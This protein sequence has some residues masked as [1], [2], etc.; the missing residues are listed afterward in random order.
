MLKRLPKKFGLL[1]LISLIPTLALWIPFYFRIPNVM[2]IPVPENGMA[3]I[4][5]NYDGPLYIVIAKTFYNVSLIKESFSF[6]LPVQ[7]YAAHFPFYPALIFLIGSGLKAVFGNALGFTWGMLITTLISSV[8][9][10]WMFKRYIALHVDK[11]D[12]LWLTFLFAVFPARWLIVRSVGSPEPLFV[13][14]ILASIFY[15]E[16]KNYLIA[17]I[18]GALAQL[19]KS[20]GILLFVAYGL[21]LF[22]PHVKKIGN[23]RTFAWI[24]SFEWKAYPLLL[25]PISLIGLF[26]VYQYTFSDFLAYFHSGD[27]IH[28][29]FP[30]FQ[31]FNYSQSWVGTFWLEEIIFVYLFI[32]LAAI[33]LFKNKHIAPAMFTTVFFISIIFVSHRDIIR[34]ALPVLPYI[35]LAFKKELVSKEVKYLF[36]FLLIP[37]YLFSLAYLSNNVMPVSDWSPFL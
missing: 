30:P 33:K 20:P 37:V 12:V 17:A 29:L 21:A 4:I 16:K 34:Y 35:Y 28:L 31:I 19:T 13:G 9:C 11:K 32:A 24:K 22:I 18:F 26:F 23:S 10:I 5:A 1:L 8:F 3:T 36:M 25:I 2:G 15:F 14:L 7:Y 27:N 6:P